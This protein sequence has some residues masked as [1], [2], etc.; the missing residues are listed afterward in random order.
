MH[1]DLTIRENLNYSARMRLAHD[2][3]AAQRRS[4]VSKVLEL[5]GLN[6]VQDYRVSRTVACGMARTKS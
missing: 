1:E 3:T 5:L 2:C 6:A 4:V